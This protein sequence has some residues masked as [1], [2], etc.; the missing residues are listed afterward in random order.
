MGQ[1]MGGKE[2]KR[3]V[4]VYALMALVWLGVYWALRGVA[5]GC[6]GVSCDR[7]IVWSL[8]LPIV[9]YVSALA[10]GGLGWN[11]AKQEGERNWSRLVGGLTLAGI[12][13]PLIALVVWRDNPDWFVVSASVLV[14]LGPISSLAYSLVGRRE[15]AQ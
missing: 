12:V 4:V 1:R 3:R 13:G 15:Q 6:A 14:S 8:V 9:V 2:Q 5:S 11:A 10:S 7:Y